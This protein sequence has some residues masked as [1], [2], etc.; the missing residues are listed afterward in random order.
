M[1]QDH[2]EQIQA[3]LQNAVGMPEETKAELLKLLTALKSELGALSETHEEAASSV[4]KFAAASTDEATRPEQKPELL[5]AALDGL[6]ASVDGL[7]SS[8]PEL[9]QLVNR[10]AL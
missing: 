4:V 7:E 10:I 2:I 3:K 6:T 5:E 8:H 9:T 1:I